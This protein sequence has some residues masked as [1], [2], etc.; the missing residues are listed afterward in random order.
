MAKWK[1]SNTNIFFQVFLLKAPALLTVFEEAS[2][3][4]L[5]FMAEEEDEDNDVQSKFQ[6]CKDWILIEEV[7]YR[8]PYN[9][10]YEKIVNTY[11]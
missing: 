6:I 3:A 10:Q 4:M 11:I 1:E 9:E 7:N 5:S 8:H 2:K